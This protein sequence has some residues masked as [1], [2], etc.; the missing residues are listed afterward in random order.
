MALPKKVKIREVGPREGFQTL[1]A[2]VPTERKLELIE[3][4]SGTGLKDIE[5]NS[6][7][8]PD[9]VPQMADAVD[10]VERY[11]AHPGINY[12]GLYLNPNG[13]LRAEDTGRLQNEGW[14]YLA[15]SETF[16]KRNSNTT[17]AAGIGEI[18]RWIE[19][20]RSRGKGVRGIMLSTAFG[21]NFEGAIPTGK[22]V[23]ILQQVVAHVE[24]SGGK[25]AEI[26][27]ADT[28]GWATPVMLQERIE[29]VRREFPDSVV[30]LH[31]HDTRGSGMANVYAGL[32]VGVDIF[33]C[34]IG[35]LGGCPFA[36]GAA[37]NVPTEDVAFLC[38]E[39]GIS[40]GLELAKLAEA[41]VL[42]E[43]IVGASLPGKFYKTWRS[44][45]EG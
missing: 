33:D 24:S 27:L 37:G 36:R 10:V 32:E 8:R 11:V 38:E 6:F 34:S 39:L 14:L 13:F 45:C 30:S 9:K 15:A 7:V 35:G 18:P 29:A 25:L 40:T 21:C 5:I 43:A 17:V 42:A 2:V 28:M 3:A 19:A 4:L 41:A 1:A 23:S 44:R 12:T 26:C 16:L 20:F 22:I 31:L